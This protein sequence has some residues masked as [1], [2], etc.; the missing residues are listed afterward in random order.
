[1][2]HHYPEYLIALM[3]ERPLDFIDQFGVFGLIWLKDVAVFLSMRS[4]RA[5]GVSWPSDGP[6]L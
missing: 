2:P 6:S 3:A 1:L 4:F 5:V